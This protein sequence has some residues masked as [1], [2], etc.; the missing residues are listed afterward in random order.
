MNRPIKFRAKGFTTENKWYYGGIH[1]SLNDTY[2]M[3]FNC[4]DPTKYK[5]V[6]VKPETLGQFTGLLDKNDTEIYEGDI[7][8]ISNNRYKVNWNDK[9]A[10]F[11]AVDPEFNETYLIID[12]DISKIAVIGNIYDNPDLIQTSN[13]GL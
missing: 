11:T 9:L 8:E 10:A 13:N 1:I 7:I 4:S 6:V 3:V 12:L 2:Y 5:M